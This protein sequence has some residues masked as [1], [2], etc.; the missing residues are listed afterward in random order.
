MERPAALV[1][2]AAL[3]LASSSQG[4]ARA[5]PAAVPALAAAGAPAGAPADAEPALGALA[6][7]PVGNALPSAVPAGAPLSGPGDRQPAPEARAAAPTAYDLPSAA[8]AGAPAAAEA[9]GAK[10]AAAAASA[11][12]SQ[13]TITNV[14]EARAGTMTDATRLF[15]AGVSSK[16]AF[17][18]DDTNSTG[19]ATGRFSVS[20]FVSDDFVKDGMWLNNPQAVVHATDKATGNDTTLVLTLSGPVYNVSAG[21]LAFNVTPA[22]AGAKPKLSGGVSESALANGRAVNLVVPAEGLLLTDVAMFIDDASPPGDAVGRKGSFFPSGG[23]G[24]GQLINMPRPGEAEPGRS[25][26][27][28]N[29]GGGMGRGYGGSGLGVGGL[30]HASVGGGYGGGWDRY[31]RYSDCQNTAMCG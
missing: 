15:L 1:L 26:S 23:Q 16:V 29:R 19:R 14:L 10:A 13:A 25:A 31:Y 8:P 27:A 5:L 17:I 11:D 6:A 20:S 12:D 7:A 28:N 9:P 3:L 21:T 24:S 4:E 22:A 30:I 2:L 18:L